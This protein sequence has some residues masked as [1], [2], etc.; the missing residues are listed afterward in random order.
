MVRGAAE[1]FIERFATDDVRAAVY[2][3]LDNGYMLAGSQIATSDWSAALVYSGDAEVHV[4]VERSQWYLD[5]A[6]A[7]G[8]RRSRTTSWS[9]PNA[10][11]LTGTAFLPI[12]PS[13]CRDTRGNYPLG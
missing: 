13:A 9:P 3:L 2:W 4:G 12:W 10:L 6:P 1:E 8:S 7:P 11:R 5:I